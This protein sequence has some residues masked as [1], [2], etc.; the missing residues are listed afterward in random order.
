MDRLLSLQAFV[1]T[2]E[3]GALAKAARELKLSPVM[4]GK[5]LA[6]LEEQFGARLLHRTTRR[7]SLTDPG[8]RAYES[9]LQIMREY[10]QMTRAIETSQ[11]VPTGHLRI[12]APVAFAERVGAILSEFS[13]TYPGVSMDILCDDR[14]L[15]MGEHRLDLAIRVGKL[16]DSS[17]I[18]RRLAPAP[19][20]VC[21]SPSYLAAHGEPRT[22]SE[23]ADHECVAYE[24]QWTG[25]GW[26]FSNPGGP[27]EIVVRLVKV[28]HRSNNAQVQR[29][30]V[31]A[32]K[33]LA[34]MPA[35]VVDDDIKAGRLVAVLTSVPQIERWVHAVYP[36]G[37]H[38]PLAIRV[39]VDFLIA[40]FK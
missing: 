39:L 26:A 8:R 27:G 29:E 37:G 2:V 16:P 5:H 17:L 32:G 18:A 3:L 38:L 14:T 10:E 1:R 6:S 7:I 40:R 22:L 11:S 13:A 25:Q 24:H 9:A 19:V 30:L 36:S 20:V 12:T 4:V 33:G 23:L 31:L 35:F 21:A 15:D 34:Q 28:K